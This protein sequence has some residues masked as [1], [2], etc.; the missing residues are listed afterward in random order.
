MGISDCFENISI[1]P[2]VWFDGG[3]KRNAYAAILAGFLVK[4]F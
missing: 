2:C 4:N 1:P 3:L